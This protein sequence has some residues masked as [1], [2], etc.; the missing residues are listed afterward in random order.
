MV[1]LP[2]GP[3]GP[4]TPH[5]PQGP[6]LPQDLV[7][8]TAAC[9]ALFE[10]YSGWTEGCFGTTLGATEMNHL[11]T[12]CAERGSLPGIGA[13]VAAIQGCGAQIAASSCAALPLDCIIPDYDGFAPPSTLAFLT[14][15]DDAAYHL[16]PRAP[17]Q[18]ASGSPASTV[19]A[20]ISGCARR[21]SEAGEEETRYRE[22]DYAGSQAS[23]S[24]WGKV[25]VHEP[26]SMPLTRA[27]PR[28]SRRPS[29][30][31]PSGRAMR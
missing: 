20:T 3:Q 24:S 6:S 12:T 2:Q 17:G 15:D 14:S 25:T 1:N 22:I 7:A 16:F 18:L 28:S 11:V 26:G 23:M 31:V 10:S 21:S 29:T 19:S 27:R 4:R 5:E 13:T 8:T 9:T 30:E